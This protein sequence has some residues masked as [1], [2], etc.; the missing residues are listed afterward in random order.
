ML[1]NI[2]NLEGVTVLNKKQQ[3]GIKGGQTCI[4]TVRDS[5]GSH[6]IIAPGFREGS[7]GSDQASGIC[8]DLLNDFPDAYSCGYDCQYD[9]FG[10]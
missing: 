2:L 6:S 8:N 9:D 3:T 10:Q 1:N 4:I 5:E 7:A